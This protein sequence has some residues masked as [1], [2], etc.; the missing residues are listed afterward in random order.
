LSAL[1]LSSALSA[2]FVIPPHSAE[3]SVTFAVAEVLAAHE[4]ANTN[5]VAKAD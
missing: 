2:I 3:V 5:A 1:S 4:G